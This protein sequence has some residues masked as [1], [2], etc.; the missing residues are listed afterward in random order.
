MEASWANQ[1]Q[2]KHPRTHQLL[3]HATRVDVGVAGAMLLLL[4][5]VE[6]RGAGE[7]VG[8][9]VLLTAPQHRA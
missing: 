5:L 8:Q 7:E 2:G 4:H 9:G 6:E 1:E 3:L